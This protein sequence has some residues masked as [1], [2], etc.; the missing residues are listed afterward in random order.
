ML[1]QAKETTV[2]R[3]IVMIHPPTDEVMEASKVAGIQVH[4]FDALVKAGAEMADRPPI[5]PPSPADL[6]VVCYTSGTTG[7]PKG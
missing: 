1:E 7:D 2:L 4:S 3:H 5:T 6:A